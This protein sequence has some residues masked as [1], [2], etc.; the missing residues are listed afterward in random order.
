[1][2]QSKTIPDSDW[3]DGFLFVGNH[4]TLD[5]L[6]TRPVQNGEPLELLSDF[7]ALLRWFHA[8]GQRAVVAIKL[9]VA[10]IRGPY[11]GIALEAVVAIIAGLFRRHCPAPGEIISQRAGIL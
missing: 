10:L 8:V 4:L 11:R 5:F 9:L 7:S 2:K 1:M 3:R 6:N